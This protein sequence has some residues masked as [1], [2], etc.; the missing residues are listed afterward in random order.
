MA[1][2]VCGCPEVRWLLVSTVAE[3]FKCSRKAVY[4]LLYAGAVDGVRIGAGWRVDHQ[5]LDAF[6]RKEAVLF[7]PPADAPPSGK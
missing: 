7:P 5:S 4:R 3:H 6:V 1:C 2:Q